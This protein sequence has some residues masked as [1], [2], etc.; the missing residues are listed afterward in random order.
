MDFFLFF[1]KIFDKIF[2]ETTLG[3]VWSPSVWDKLFLFL[4]RGRY[5]NSRFEETV[6]DL[7]SLF[8]W[9]FADKVFVSVISKLFVRK[10]N[11]P[12]SLRAKRKAQYD[13]MKQL[14]VW[15]TKIA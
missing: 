10:L 4:Q 12:F 15:V 2:F 6:D 1:W 11:L 14:D 13:K 7:V 3:M 5:E 8:P 9:V